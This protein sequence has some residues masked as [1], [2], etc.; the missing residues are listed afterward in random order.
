MCGL[1]WFSTVYYANVFHCK[2]SNGLVWLCMVLYV[3][4]RTYAQFLCLLFIRILQFVKPPVDSKPVSKK[5]FNLASEV[6]I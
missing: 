1:V 3:A 2:I 6:Q 4:I 5:L